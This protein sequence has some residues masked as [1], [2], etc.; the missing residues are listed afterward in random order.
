MSLTQ[1]RKREASRADL[2]GYQTHPTGS[3]ARVRHEAHPMVGPLS[4]L[5]ARQCFPEALIL[6]AKNCSSLAM[7]CNKYRAQNRAISCLRK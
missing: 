4:I 3:K 7:L 6:T 1:N 2:K 5:V